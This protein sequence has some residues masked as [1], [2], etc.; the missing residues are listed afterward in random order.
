M[1]ADQLAKSCGSNPPTPECV[2]VPR[3][4]SAAWP[5]I[6]DTFSKAFW[7][8]WQGGDAQT[9]LDKAAKAIDLDYADND[10]YK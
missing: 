9:E 2:T 8:I 1:Y 7:A 10:G 6:N 4:I 5:V 3:T